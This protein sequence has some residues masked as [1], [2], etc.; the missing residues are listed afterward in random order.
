VLHTFVPGC[1]RVDENIDCGI[2]ARIQHQPY[3]LSELEH[4]EPQ[5]KVPAETRWPARLPMSASCLSAGARK[6]CG[7]GSPR[8]RLSRVARRA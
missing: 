5:V 2:N 3:G 1:D 6:P 7:S 4:S 8:E